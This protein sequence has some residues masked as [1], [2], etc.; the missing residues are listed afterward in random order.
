[1]KLLLDVGNSR[2]KWAWADDGGLSPQTAVG[3]DGMAA[4][5]DRLG[6]ERR[7]DQ[8]LCSVVA[9]TEVEDV[10]LDWCR[11]AY[12]MEAR[13]ARVEKTCHGLVN[14]YADPSS[15]G[16]DRWMAML[17]A[18]ELT[19]GAFCVVDSGTAITVDR[20]DP[21]GRHLGGWILPGVE[22]MS[23]SLAA[24]TARVSPDGR[25]MQDA[26]GRNTQE[27]VAAGV[28]AAVDGSML[29][30]MSLLE[31]KSDAIFVTGGAAEAVMPVL[32]ERGRLVPDLV[33]RGLLH[34][35]Q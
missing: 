6:A 32:G 24:G 13:F 1:M 11:N 15:M 25:S 28:Q 16:V 14:A 29:R 19:E 4:A 8:V 9:D 2:V 10:L 27:C 31:E 33:L 23:R 35:S 30:M 7:A 12:D 3:R 18:A 26:W 5:L 34:W 20:V 21:E 22:L 17:G